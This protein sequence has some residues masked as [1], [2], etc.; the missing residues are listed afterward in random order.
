MPIRPIAEC[1]TF[2]VSSTLVTSFQIFC[3]CMINTSLLMKSWKCWE[4]GVGSTLLIQMFFSLNSLL[5]GDFSSF[6]ADIRDGT[7]EMPSVQRKV[8]KIRV[9]A[10]QFLFTVHMEILEWITKNIILFISPSMWVQLRMI[11]SYF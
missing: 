8:I 5:T 9:A 4:T 2:Q 11:I 3:L 1:L 7:L 10:R 6:L